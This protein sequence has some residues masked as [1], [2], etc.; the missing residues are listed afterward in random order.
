VPY[1]TQ[2]EM[3]ARFG[4]RE[5][6]AL[7]DRASPP[8]GAID[9]AVVAQAI[10]D[11]DAEI[12][13][14]LNGRYKVPLPVVPNVVK[15]ISADIARYRLF[16]DKAT[17]EVATRYKDALAWLKDVARGVVNLIDSNGTPLEAASDEN[18]NSAPAATEK[19]V[20]FNSGNFMDRYNEPIP[21][22][23]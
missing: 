23:S 22:A 16:D 10:T 21:G 19:V 20:A 9:P 15:R 11:A 18:T 17:E 6:L 14:Y 4:T 8:A 12:D 3:E 13:S 7:T 1:T 5:L 2:A